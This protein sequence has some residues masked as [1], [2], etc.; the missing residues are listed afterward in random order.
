[1]LKH[2]DPLLGP[3][4]LQ[5]LRAMGHGDELAIVDANFPATSVAQRLVRLDSVSAT[6]TLE[7][8]VSVLPIDNFI[9][10]PVVRMEVVGAP[11]E[12]PE[13]A[14]EFGRIV[15]SAQPEVGIGKI[16]RFAF[17]ER[18]RSA[19]AVVQTGEHRLYGCL[20]ITKGIIRPDEV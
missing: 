16:D 15:A 10:T 14:R 18:A 12:I 3:E 17:Y 7:A 2:I 9:D 13:V 20:I 19:Y 11:D 8:V 1:M 5:I 6:R 4:L